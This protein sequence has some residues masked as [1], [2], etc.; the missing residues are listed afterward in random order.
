MK[1]NL[2]L[3][4]LMLLQAPQLSDETA[5]EILDF[6][7]HLTEAFESCYYGQLRRYEQ[8]LEPEEPLHPDLFD[9]LYDELPD[10]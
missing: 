8:S 5:A 6:L 2:N 1:H 10:F 4:E 7:Y 9:D 3:F